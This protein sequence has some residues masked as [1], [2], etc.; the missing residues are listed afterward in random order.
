MKD[1]RWSPALVQVIFVY[2]GGQLVGKRGIDFWFTDLAQ[3]P[4]RGGTGAVGA[5]AANDVYEYRTVSRPYNV[6]R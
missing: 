4:V 3:L 2:L 5:I 1:C 6:R